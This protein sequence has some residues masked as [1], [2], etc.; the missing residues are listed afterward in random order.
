MSF[1]NN[2]RTGFSNE[3]MDDVWIT[4]YIN[5]EAVLLSIFMEDAIELAATYCKHS[6]RKGIHS[7]DIIMALKT[8][9]YLGDAFWNRENIQERITNVRNEIFGTENGYDEEIYEEN[10]EEFYEENDE[11]FYEENN[12][13]FHSEEEEP[14]TKSKDRCS[15]C[16]AMN[17]VQNKWDQ[18]NPENTRVRD[19]INNTI[20]K[21]NQKF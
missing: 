10:D 12:E 8:R 3:N 17:D 5:N 11:E 19:V 6:D 20:N 9:A 13:E 4:N 18:W 15:I 14:W 7:T 2:M 16:L 1:P 21:L